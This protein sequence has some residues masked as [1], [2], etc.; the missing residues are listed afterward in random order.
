MQDS[1]SG[2]EFKSRDTTLSEN[3]FPKNGVI[4]SDRSLYEMQ[5]QLETTHVHSV[6]ELISQI[7][8]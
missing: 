7:M 5:E 8:S 4:C 2:S 6:G 3:E 1:G